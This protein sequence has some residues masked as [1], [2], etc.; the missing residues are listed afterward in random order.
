VELR[1]PGGDTGAVFFGSGALTD[2]KIEIIGVELV[3]HSPLR[4]AMAADETIRLHGGLGAALIDVEHMGSTSIPGIMAKPIVDLIPVVTNLDA[5]DAAQARIEA[6]GYD[7][8]GEF[9]IPTR[10]RLSDPATGKRLFQLHC[11]AQDSP[12]IARHLAFRD[13]LRAHRAIAKDYDAR[14]ERAAALH[15]DNVL[16]YNDA[17]SDWIKRTEQAALAWWKARG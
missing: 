5:L 2:P 10:C 7:Y 11:F 9:G 8:L 14:K 13:Y 4:A 6:L 3:P 15:P 12:Q 1:G 16:L 17:K